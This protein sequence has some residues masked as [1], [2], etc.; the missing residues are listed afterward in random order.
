MDWQ[1][2]LP[3]AEFADKP[4]IESEEVE[5]CP[6]CD[7]SRFHQHAVG[8]DYE[9]LTCRNPWRFVR[10]EKCAHV[11]LNPRPTVANLS[12]IYPPT[13]YSYNYTQQVNAIARIGKQWLDSGKMKSIVKRLDRAPRSYLDIGC[14]DGRFL[15]TMEKRGIPRDRLYGLELDERVVG[16]LVAEGYQAYNRRVEDCTEISPGSIDLATMFHV[17]E[18]VADP[19]S[20]VRKIREWLP[21]GGVLAAETPNVD[22]LDAR[23]FSERF[24]GGYHI[25]RHWNLFSPP[26]LKK[27]FEDN[28]FDVIATSFQTGHSFWMYSYQHSLNFGKRPNKRLARFFNPLKSLAFLMA[29]TAFDKLRAAMGAR[30][31]A[32]LMLA[33]R[34]D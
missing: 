29:F 14:G 1:A 12:I 10:C 2:T 21:V 15:R 30:T 27:L 18:H 25:P 8:F 33:R 3:P 31:S 19:A 16:S 23:K 20:V 24:W 22:S 26:T 28:G 6:V 11:W 32:M 13:Y 17:I 4:I 7:G 9:S 5:R 34:R